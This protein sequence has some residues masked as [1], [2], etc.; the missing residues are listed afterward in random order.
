M[1]D[2]VFSY[3]PGIVPQREAATEGYGQNLWLHG[4]DDAL[5]EVSIVNTRLGRTALL[6]EK[7]RLGLPTSSSRSSYPMAV[8]KRI[9]PA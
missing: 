6:R 4:E 9:L 7:D 8:S 2:S 1:A 5:T 3:A